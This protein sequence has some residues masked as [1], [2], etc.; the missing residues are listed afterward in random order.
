MV[1]AGAEYLTEFIET[2][3]KPIGISILTTPPLMTEFWNRKT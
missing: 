3:L 2:G 1:F